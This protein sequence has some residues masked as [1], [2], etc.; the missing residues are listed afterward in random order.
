MDVREYLARHL[1]DHEESARGVKQPTFF[2]WSEA[3][4]AQ[5][6][7][8]ALSFLYG[9]IPDRF[10]K[11]ETREI[12][13]EDCVLYFCDRCEK[14]MG[15][16]DLEIDGK[17]CIKLD[18]KEERELKKRDLLDML[19]IGCS[20]KEEVTEDDEEKKNY[21]WEFVKNSICTVK[22]ENPLPKGSKVRYLCS[23]KPSL[24]ELESM[25][26]FMPIVAEY[27]AF[28]LYR[29]DS[30]SRSNLERAQLHFQALELL[31]RTKLAI[32]L[33]L[34]N[35]EHI[36]GLRQAQD[37]MHSMRSAPGSTPVPAQPAASGR[38]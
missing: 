10:S 5:A 24:E 22:F 19:H 23:R 21:T 17:K 31:V 25:D 15:I 34:R 33:D 18:E 9:L 20:D 12:E 2:T 36:F 30:E 7:E 6:V 16:V 11:L 32:E 38:R 8:L 1:N 3:H 14:F 13:E 4:V 29:T 27:A 28:W 26:E 37:E 35:N